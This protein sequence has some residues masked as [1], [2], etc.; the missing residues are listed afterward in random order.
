MK[1]LLIILLITSSQAL[2]ANMNYVAQVTSQN[3][4]GSERTRLY[5]TTKNNCQKHLKLIIK[6]SESTVGVTKTYGAKCG[7]ASYLIGF[8]QGMDMGVP[9]IL[10]SNGRDV[11]I[12]NGSSYRACLGIAQILRTNGVSDAR[13]IN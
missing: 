7:D 8:F 2:S 9:Y 13:C 10:S 6:Q 11:V 12:L 3:V 5:L 1:F 4:D